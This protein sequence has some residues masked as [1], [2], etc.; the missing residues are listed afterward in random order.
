MNDF[1]T[2]WTE[3]QKY[4]D[5]LE[6]SIRYNEI[7]HN[8]KNVRKHIEKILKVRKAESLE[9]KEHREILNLIIK[10]FEVM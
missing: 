7:I 8:L 1:K 4:Y 3:S 9:T 2:Y 10:I 6:I 5:K